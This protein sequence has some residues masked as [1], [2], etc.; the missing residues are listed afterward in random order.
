MTDFAQK[1][2]SVAFQIYLEV[3][4]SVF[5]GFTQLTHHCVLA[6]VCLF[7]RWMKRARSG[8]STNWRKKKRKKRR[9]RKRKRK[10]RR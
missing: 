9:R 4:L 3:I 2:F 10:K 8:L 1:T 6:L 5:P 7:E